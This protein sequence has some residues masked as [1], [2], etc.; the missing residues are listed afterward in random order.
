MQKESPSYQMVRLEKEQDRKRESKS[1][2]ERE[3]ERESKGQREQKSA[4]T[5]FIPSH[6]V[7]WETWD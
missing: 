7:G 5:W 3:R 6:T 1:K 2:R 4:L